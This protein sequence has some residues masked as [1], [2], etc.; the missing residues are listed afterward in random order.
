MLNRYIIERKIPGVGANSDQDFSN[1]AIKSNEVLSALGPK[2][3][4]V[5]SFVTDDKVYCEYLAENEGLVR[6]HAKQGGFPADSILKVSHICDPTS[7]ESDFS[8]I[9]KK[10]NSSDEVNNQLS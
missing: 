10:A 3:Q 7:A 1:M 5:K 2:I 6:E 9:D 8:A 4:W